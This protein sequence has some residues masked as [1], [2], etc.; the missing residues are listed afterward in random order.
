MRL[1]ELRRNQKMIFLSCYILMLCAKNG[2][3]FVTMSISMTMQQRQ[4]S[5]T[6]DHEIYSDEFERMICLLVIRIDL[7]RIFKHFDSRVF[8][9]FKALKLSILELF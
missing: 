7:F 1:P 5:I 6:P 3:R 8:R 9:H 4:N 2:I